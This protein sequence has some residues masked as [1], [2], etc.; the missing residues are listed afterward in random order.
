MINVV[1]YLPRH[2]TKRYASRKTSDISHII[3]HHGAGD[4][5]PWSYARFHVQDRDWPGI[6][7]HVVL[8]PDGIPFKTNNDTTVCYHASGWNTKA[9]GICLAGN[10]S[11][12]KLSFHQSLVLLETIRL[13]RVAYGI[14]SSNI[15]GHGEV[16][17][18]EC[19]G[20]TIDMDALREAV[21][22]VGL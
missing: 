19:P 11:R 10:F 8:T 14:P 1:N 5:D 20:D 2:T 16:A 12:R 13:Y 7:Y 9:I 21:R 15:L 4:G 18:T 22:F 17:S 6:G 3:I